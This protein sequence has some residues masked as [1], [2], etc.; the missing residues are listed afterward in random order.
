MTVAIE[1]HKDFHAR[2]A[3]AART[4]GNEGLAAEHERVGRV[5]SRRRASEAIG[6]AIASGVAM[7]GLMEILGAKKAHAADWPGALERKEL[8]SSLIIGAKDRE[9][10]ARLLEAAMSDSSISV[11]DFAD[12]LLDDDRNPIAP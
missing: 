5:W 1:R 11:P 12:L 4:M 10:R 6:T 3:D 9:T 8:Y 2:M 7:L